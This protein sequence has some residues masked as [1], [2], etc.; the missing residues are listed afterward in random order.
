MGINTRTRTYFDFMIKALRNVG[1]LYRY[2]IVCKNFSVAYKLI[3]KKMTLYK[4]NV[5][6]EY[7]FSFLVGS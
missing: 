1:S 2:Y 3:K 4:K 6:A 5:P 7:M